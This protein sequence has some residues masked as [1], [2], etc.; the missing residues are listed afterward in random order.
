[1]NQDRAFRG[2]WIPKE[3][4]LSKNLTLQQKV[5]LVEIDSLDKDDGCYATN[6][7]FSEFFGLSTKRVSVVINSLVEK[8]LVK[9]QI[10]KTLGNKRILTI[11]DRYPRNVPYPIPENGDTLSPESSTYILSDSVSDNKDTAPFGAE[12]D[13]AWKEYPKK[14]G[15]KAAYRSY[16]AQRRKGVPARDLL[17]ATKKYASEQIGKDLQFVKNGSTFWGRDEPFRDYLE[18]ATEICPSVCPKC[19]GGILDHK[20]YSCGWEFKSENRAS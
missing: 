13:E 12:F 11:S 20:C 16:V 6:E 15:K 17:H 8:G 18:G 14:S 5:F 9:S 1:M 4:W 7:Y 19:G 3:I 10:N 2:I